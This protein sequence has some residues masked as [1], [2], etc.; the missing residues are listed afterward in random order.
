MTK[1]GISSMASPPR[2]RVAL[3]GVL[4]TAALA[5]SLQASAALAADPGDRHLGHGGTRGRGPGP[6]AHRSRLDP[7]SQ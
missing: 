7:G 1:R 5:V 6:A 2:T 3:A 4:M